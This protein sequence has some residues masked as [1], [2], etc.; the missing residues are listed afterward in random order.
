MMRKT[1][2]RGGKVAGFVAAVAVAGTLAASA[3]PAI[4]SPNSSVFLPAALAATS[5][6]PNPQLPQK[7]GLNL[8][9]VFDLSN[10]MSDADVSTVKS[11]STEAVAALSGT[12]TTLGV[13]SFATFA[14]QELAATSL[15]SDQGTASVIGSINALTRPGET[16]SWYGGTN[17]Q[18]GLAI[19]PESSYD[20]VIFFTDGVPTFYGEN[21]LNDNENGSNGTGGTG[22]DSGENPATSLNA[23]IPEANALKDSGTRIIGVGVKGAD[24]GRLSQ[25]TG[26]VPDSDYYTTNYDQLATTLKGIATA[27][28]TG[29]LNINKAVEA[30]DSSETTPGEG[31]IFDA[32]A[33]GAEETSLTTDANGQASLKLDFPAQEPVTV[34]VRERQ[35]DGYTVVQKSSFNA[36]CT[37]DGEPLDVVNTDDAGNVGFA[38]TAT[39]GSVTSCTVTNKAPV[40]AWTMEKTSDTDGTVNPGDTITYSVEARNTG[41]QA[42]EGIAFRDDLTTVLDH[43]V[44]VPAS[45]TLAIGGAGALV[46]SDPVAGILTAGPFALAKGESARLSYQVKVNDDAFGATLTNMVVGTGEIPPVACLEDKPCTTTDIVPP[47]PTVPPT[48]TPTPT[49]PPTEIPTET[50]SSIGTP[51]A[52]VT[53]ATPVTQPASNSTTPSVPADDLAYTGA[54][55][56]L[57][58]IIGSLMLVGGLLLVMIRR[59]RRTH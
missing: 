49:V 24:A 22:T 13:Y 19:V 40:K 15:A 56:V 34:A 18:Q 48:V 53:P 35:Q 46:V 11:A 25:I 7:C 2:W 52:S 16:K 47:T 17:W 43:A 9:M 58:V 28:C 41:G 23:A 12:G 45:A 37:R 39:S 54:S 31:W 8:A 51:S 20:G 1:F 30:F 50:P 55:A 3:L 26:A 27:G 38:V 57:P 59:L 29:T 21:P 14:K 32:I 36:V 5:A 42:V 10:S 6:S 33:G 44:F 4:A